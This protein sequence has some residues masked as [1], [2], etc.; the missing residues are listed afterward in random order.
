MNSL[1]VKNKITENTLWWPTFGWQHDLPIFSLHRRSVIK[2]ADI[3]VVVVVVAANIS[4]GSGGHQQFMFLFLFPT[5]FPLLPLFLPLFISVRFLGFGGGRRFVEE[6]IALFEDFVCVCRWLGSTGSRH[7]RVAA[8]AA[9]A[10]ARLDRAEA[11]QTRAAAI[12]L[13]LRG[14][15]EFLFAATVASH[16]SFPTEFLGFNAPLLD[17]DLLGR[18]RVEIPGRLRAVVRGS[19]RLGRL[20]ERAFRGGDRRGYRSSSSGEVSGAQRVSHL[21]ASLSIYSLSPTAAAAVFL[22]DVQAGS[23]GAGHAFD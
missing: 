6:E 22:R 7:R 20:D 3:V 17:S 2:S 15:L 21:E 12:T 23:E 10:A 9:A 4:P 14:L 5:S 11:P 8:A 16:S 1:Q 19:L 18:R 13:L